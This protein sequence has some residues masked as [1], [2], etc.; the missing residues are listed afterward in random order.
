MAEAKRE[1]S[2]FDAQPVVLYALSSATDTVAHPVIFAPSYDSYTGSVIPVQIGKYDVIQNLPVTIDFEHHQIHEGE[3]FYAQHIDTA[4]DT[5][6]IKFGFIPPVTPSSGPCSCPHVIVMC[7]VYNGAA[8]VDIYEGTNITGGVL[9]TNFNRQRSSL[10]TSGTLVYRNVTAST[11]TLIESFFVGQGAKSVGNNRA[12]SELVFDNSK[13]YR[14]DVTGLVGGTD[15][16]VSFQWY[17]EC[18]NG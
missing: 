3:F 1:Y 6:T 7:D 8:R 9:L 17:E 15:A 13:T 14:V 11:G 10:N 16:I 2:A 12:D 18:V 4:L 5:S